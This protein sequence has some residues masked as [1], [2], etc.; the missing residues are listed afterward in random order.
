MFL[1]II[2][3]LSFDPIH[4]ANQLLVFLYKDYQHKRQIGWVKDIYFAHPTKFAIAL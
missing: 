2:T 3:K 4:D 1:G